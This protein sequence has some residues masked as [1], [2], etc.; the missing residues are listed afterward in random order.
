MWVIF[1][2]ENMEQIFAPSFITFLKIFTLFV[3]HFHS[4]STKGILFLLCTMINLNI[5][6]FMLRIFIQRGNKIKKKEKNEKWNFYSE[7]G[8][9]IIH[10]I[11]VSEWVRKMLRENFEDER[12]KMYLICVWIHNDICRMRSLLRKENFP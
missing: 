12:R 5:Y 4:Y 11:R 8:Q 9:L 6:I 7:R 3:S 2:Y 1:V 10:E